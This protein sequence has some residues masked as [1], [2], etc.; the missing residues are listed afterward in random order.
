MNG[1]FKAYITGF[2][3][4]HFKK[5]ENILPV[6]SICSHI[7]YIEKGALRVFYYDSKG[8]NKTHWFSF[9][10]S[11][12]TILSGVLY[13]KRMPYGIEA[14]EDSEIRLIPKSVIEEKMFSSKET[15]QLLFETVSKAAIAIADRLVDLQIKTARER[16]EQLLE[17]HPNIFQRAKLEHIASYL[18]ITQQS[19]SRIRAQK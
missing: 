12:I 11:T 13:H 15:S 2:P 6:N 9:E 10:E 1:S 18:G 16:Y 8:N 14:I 7:Y 17:K 19:L 4:M 3:K 5:G